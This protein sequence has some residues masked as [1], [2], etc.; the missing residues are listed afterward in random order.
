MIVS[1]FLNPSALG[2]ANWLDAADAWTRWTGF[3][4]QAARVYMGAA[5]WSISSDMS[6]QI[7]AGCKLLISV[8]PSY[9]PVSASDLSALE[10]F[11]DQLQ[12]AGAN[13]EIAIW[14]EPFYSKLSASEY[15]AA[16]RYYGPVIRPYFPLVFLTAAQSVVSNNENSYYPGDDY[17][18]VV[19]TDIYASITGDAAFALGLCAQPADLASPLKPFGIW[20]FN[21]SPAHQTQA[22]I[23]TFFQ[24]VSSYMTNRTGFGQPC[25]DVILFNGAPGK[26]V[27]GYD[28][29][30]NAGFEGSTGNWT[31]AGG[32]TI[33]DT[34]AEHHS[35]TS[36]L[37]VTATAD[38][39]LQ[40]ANCTLSNSSGGLPCAPGDTVYASI[41]LEPDTVPRESTAQ[42]QWV[43]AVNESL[44]VT[45]G[46][47]VMTSE[48][49]WTQLTVQ[50]NAPSGTAWCRLFPS[51]SGAVIGESHYADDAELRNVTGDSPTNTMTI[52]F[53]WDYRIGLW[54]DVYNALM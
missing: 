39:L 8:Q 54:Q 31:Q 28:E 29:S 24:D 41:W 19:A 20:E 42:I 25:A 37:F 48:H 13:A 17:V 18:D 2:V 3:S 23:T 36:S 47:S 27:L 4:P 46:D 33:S 40:F 16:V 15:I 21:G 10:T 26:S 11:C 51:V 50:G 30:P 35:G 52:E 49:S 38:G 53:G 1:A 44:G 32:C 45:A 12:A 14:S 5:P 9:S 43:S 34:I 7:A 6:A 22:Q